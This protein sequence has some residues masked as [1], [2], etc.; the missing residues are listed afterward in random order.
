MEDEN[1]L[2]SLACLQAA[3]LQ[4]SLLGTH[5]Q[6]GEALLGQAPCEEWESQKNGRVSIATRLFHVSRPLIVANKVQFDV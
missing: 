3:L 6:V 4:Q 5:L 1:F 2:L